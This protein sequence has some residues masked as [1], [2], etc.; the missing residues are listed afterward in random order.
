MLCNP[1]SRFGSL[2]VFLG[3]MGLSACGGGGTS[4]GGTPSE[5]ETST[6]L[7][8]HWVDECNGWTPANPIYTRCSFN[9]VACWSLKQTGS[10]VEATRIEDDASWGG[11]PRPTVLSGT[12]SGGR[13]T[14]TVSGPGNPSMHTLSLTRTRIDKWGTPS[15]SGK[16][17]MWKGVD[18]TFWPRILNPI[19]T[20]NCTKYWDTKIEDLP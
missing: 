4:S 15:G 18:V 10:S 20:Q 1:P 7:T 3:F 17:Y 11:M 13:L 16:Y 14:A 12:V 2:F 19:A 6:S 9:S 8:G 5:T